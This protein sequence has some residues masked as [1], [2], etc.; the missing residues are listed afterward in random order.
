MFFCLWCGV[1]S[2]QDLTELLNRLNSTSQPQDKIVPLKELGIY[3]QKKQA[4]TKSIEYFEQALQFEKQ[5]KN[6]EAQSFSTRQILSKMYASSKDYD[7]ALNY[8]QEI[9]EF[10][11]KNQ[12]TIGQ[13]AALDQMVLFA[14]LNQDY[15]KAIHYQQEILKI[16]QTLN[17]P[18]D[19]IKAYNNLGY[20]YHKLNKQTESLQNYQKA[21]DLGKQFSEGSLPLK[22]KAILFTN[23]GVAYTHMKDFAEAEL[24]YKQALDMA[25][26]QG[27]PSQ[28]AEAHNYLA[29][30]YYVAGQP[31]A[32]IQEAKKAIEIAKINDD[33]ESL[34]SSYQIMADVYYYQND[35][36]NAQLYLKLSQSL[37]EKINNRQRTLEQK[38]LEDQI[39]LE[40]KENELRGLIAEKEKQSLALKQSELEREKQE[41][42]LMLKEKELTLLKRNQQLQEAK[43][44]N[45]NLEQAQVRQLLLIAEEKAKNE[46]QKRETESQK[47]E[48]VKQKLIAEKEKAEKQ[49]Q[50]QA[51]LAS[52]KDQQLKD[53]QLKQAATSRKYLSVLAILMGFIALMVVLG[54]ILN[55]RK[56]HKLKQAHQQIKEKN[57]ELMSNEEELRQNMEELETTQDAMRKSQREIESKNVLLENQKAVLIKTYKKLKSKNAALT[58]SIHY[59][60]RMQQAILPS[61]AE[62][63]KIFSDFFVIYQAKDIVS[64]DFYWLKQVEHFTFVAVIDCTGHGVPGAFMS[65]IGNALLN[66]I[67]V[68]KKVFDTNI[69]LEELHQGVRKALHQKESNNT[70]GMDLVLCRLQTID[71]QTLDIQFSGAKRSLFYTKNGEIHE[72]QGDRLNIG[73]YVKSDIR[74]F[75]TTNILLESGEKLYLFTDGFLDAPNRKRKRFGMSKFKEI[76]EHNKHLPLENQAEKF[77]E[78]LVRHTENTPSRD[79]ITLLAVELMASDKKIPV[80]IDELLQNQH[81]N[82]GYHPEFDFFEYYTRI[83]A[84]EVVLSYKGPF[85]DAMLAEIGREI[86]EK[87]GNN[88]KVWKKVFNIFMELAQNVSYYSKEINHFKNND[89]VGTLL[90]LDI[91]DSYKV[92]TGNLIFQSAVEYLKNKCETINSL[93]HDELREYK[94]RLRS[95]PNANSDESKGAGIGIVQA[96]LTSSNPLEFEIRKFGEDHAFF[97]LSTRVEK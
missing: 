35:L 62:I 12:H 26:K 89:R 80:N 69:I 40:K 87:V 16:N 63:K 6:L 13:L 78:A 96:A 53:Q 55:Q 45:Q 74:Q 93:N 75:S 3:Y 27:S 25:D 83:N 56:N 65:L 8:Q 95:D 19:Q 64:G 23:I 11:K 4:Y 70:D 21:L 71:D 57:E 24:Y 51:L 49:Q 15:P 81:S 36:K 97:L 38:N 91:G 5:F 84:A 86:R 73:G 7:K 14:T 42:D 88:P 39:N 31:E 1:L 37:K 20:L 43:L 10:H 82:N 58:D 60:E 28:I 48:A 2:A 72:V 67:V 77:Q 50:Q 90:I 34:L 92:M 47:Q 29:A 76:L 68:Q 59:A 54:W 46:R 32:A 17:L 85:S 22:E 52:K 79:D 30:N 44:R 18:N 41:K 66:E 33:D 61:P 94:R 9:L